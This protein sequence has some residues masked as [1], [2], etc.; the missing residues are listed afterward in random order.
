MKR[1]ILHALAWLILIGG[2]VGAYFSYNYHEGIKAGNEA[3]DLLRDGKLR[4]AM[5]MASRAIDMRPGDDLGY[6]VR[7]AARFRLIAEQDTKESLDECKKDLNR[8]LELTQNEKVMQLCNEFL[9]LIE[10]LQST[11]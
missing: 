3:V 11:S 1:T 2:F 6:Y 7:G 8:A 10:Q 9:K 5:T 4:E